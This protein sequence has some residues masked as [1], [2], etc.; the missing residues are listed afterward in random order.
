MWANRSIHEASMWKH[1][2]CLT[3]TYDDENLPADNAVTPRDLTLFIKRLRR[4]ADSSSSSIDRDRRHS[5]RYLACGEYGERLGR[6]HYHA[7]LFNAGFRDLKRAGNYYESDTL[8]ELWP[9][10]NH[11]IDPKITGQAAAYVAQYTLTK[12]HREAYIDADGVWKQPPFLRMSLKPAIGADWL[13]KYAP[14]L[15]NG[16]LVENGRKHAVPRYYRNKVSE[17][18]PELAERIQLATQRTRL[19]LAEMQSDLKDPNRIRD[20]ETIHKARKKLQEQRNS[21]T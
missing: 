13:K 19:R 16:F 12:Q 11:K 14:D 10:G 5:I 2:N 7:L 3:L 17:L 8:R 1:N 9:H 4:H 15:S 21:F 20:S 18:Y 6:P